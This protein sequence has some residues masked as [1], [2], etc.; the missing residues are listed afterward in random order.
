MDGK[1]KKTWALM[2]M[3]LLVLGL[4]TAA[5]GQAAGKG[6]EPKAGEVRK[7]AE[8]RLDDIKDI[9]NIEADALNEQME[10]LEEGDHKEFKV[11]TDDDIV[12]LAAGD[13]YKSSGTFF[14]VKA[15]RKQSAQ[16]GV[17]VMERFRGRMEPSWKWDRVSGEGPLT[18][19]TR[20][21]LLDRFMSGGIFMYPIAALLL[22]GLI[23]A[24]RC[25][26]YFRVD[27]HCPRDLVESCGKA[28]EEGDLAKFEDLVLK[29]KGLFAHACRVMA[30]N[31]RRLTVE[32][33]KSRIEAEAIVEVGRLS[34][35]LRVLNF[36]T[37][38]SPLFGL[39]GTVQGLIMCFESLAGETATQSKAV[40]LA[41]GIKVALLTTAFGLIVALP[42][43][44]V[45]FVFNHRL[46]H[47]ANLC[48]VATEELLHELAILRREPTDA[49]RK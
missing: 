24:L 34:F 22:L 37:V 11:V 7:E 26:F 9:A 18:M 35:L 25:A 5:W 2:A 3:G 43:L 12:T 45:F 20:Q 6:P 46:S 31:M 44:M 19:A 32:E 16:G 15:I 27:L 28:V 47:M 40:A 41:A 48:G 36:V 39:L 17:F 29:R 10:E 1:A 49:G 4:G 14:K 33:L 30:A 38:A 23:V 42:I 21:T 8:I 13:L